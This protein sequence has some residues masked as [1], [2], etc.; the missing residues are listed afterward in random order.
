MFLNPFT[1][2]LDY[3]YPNTGD[4]EKSEFILVQL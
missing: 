2:V 4:G 3:S 1:G